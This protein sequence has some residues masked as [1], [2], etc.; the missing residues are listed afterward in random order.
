MLGRYVR[1]QHVITLEDAVRKMTAFP[2]QRLGLADRGL[3]RVGMKADLVVF[4]PAT[5][6][7]RATFEQ[8]H[9]YTDGVWAVI[10][11]GEVA[12]ENGAMT[13]ARPGRV[14]R[15]Q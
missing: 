6:K 13:S 7:D 3:L 11:N 15:R 9:Q 1:E 12:F 2:A 8:P 14:L 5:V 4:D 10:V